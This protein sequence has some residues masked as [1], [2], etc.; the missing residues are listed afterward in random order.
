MARLARCQCAR[1]MAERQSDPTPA[2]HRSMRISLRAAVSALLLLP[3]FGAAPLAGQQIP[4]PYRFVETGQEVGLTGGWLNLGSG[5]FDFGPESALAAGGRWAIRISGPLGFE[6]EANALSGT[7]NVIDP[8]LGEGDRVV[9][10]ADVLLG[11]V[12]G[13]LTMTLTG[14]R[15]WNGLAPFVALGGGMVFDLS[16]DQ[17]V[18]EILL[19]ED[20]FDFGNSFLGTLGVGTRLHVSRRFVLRGDARFSLYQIDTPPGFSDP[21]RGF[22]AVE[23]SEWV[24]GLGLYLTLAYRF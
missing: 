11:S 7:R 19:A 2:S 21:D 14:D 4:S 12:E 15:T 5:R 6:A 13:R 8:G 16:S 3:L 20:R 10:E 24:S 9:G 18:D 1:A 23:E 22:E 17:A